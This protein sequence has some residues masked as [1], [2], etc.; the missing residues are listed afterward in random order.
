MA[1]PSQRG[2]E[3]ADF[4]FLTPPILPVK[5]LAGR[6]FSFAL[7]SWR[8][9]RSDQA[10]QSFH[11]MMGCFPRCLSSLRSS[12]VADGMPWMT[13]AAIDFLRRVLR[14]D[15]SVFEW[16]AGGST[17]FL[18]RRV[19]SL[20]SIEHDPSWAGQ[21]E[22]AM[23]R[24]DGFSWNLQVIEAEKR[25]DQHSADPADPTAYASAVEPYRQMSFHNYAN[26]IQSHA[27]D[28]F[29]LVIVDGRSRPSCAQHGIPKVVP[30]GWL[31]LDDAGRQ[32]YRWVHEEM[33]R[34]GWQALTF[35]GPCPYS[36]AF[37]QTQMWRRPTV[38]EEAALS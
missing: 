16:G 36:M 22:A 18:S 37:G 6:L 9:S 15:M 10:C 23:N 4:V 34:L 31:L 5:L 19:R 3:D 11:E 20:M 7:Q 13:Y 27:V 28:G 1:L 38:A 30:G 26:A 17:V 21:V 25:A 8:H 32:R 14:Q 24:R 2:R 35:A 12:P 33:K 29:D